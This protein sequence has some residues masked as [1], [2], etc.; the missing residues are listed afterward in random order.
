MTTSAS[1]SGDPVVIGAY[2]EASSA[3]GVNGD[4]ANDLAPISGAAYVFT[5]VGPSAPELRL[6][7]TRNG[8][9]LQLTATGTTNT[10]WRLEFRDTATCTNGWQPLPNITLGS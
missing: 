8:D 2:N 6:A 9:L 1:R 10:N 5:G 3:T 7:A 4:Q